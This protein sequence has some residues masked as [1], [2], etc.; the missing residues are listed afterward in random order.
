MG[1]KRVPCLVLSWLVFDK[2]IIQMHF[3]QTLSTNL[4]IPPA[5]LQLP[6]SQESSHVHLYEY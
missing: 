2:E 6:E 1:R 3:I 5:I 4:H